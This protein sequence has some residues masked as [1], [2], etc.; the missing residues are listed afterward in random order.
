MVVEN[1][2]RLLKLKVNTTIIVYGKVFLHEF[3][4]FVLGIFFFMSNSVTRHFY[5]SFLVL[6]FSSNSYKLLITF[7]IVR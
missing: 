7:N 1:K 5:T 6:T 3:K 2:H 4:N